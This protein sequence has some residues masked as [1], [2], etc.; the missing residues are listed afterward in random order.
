MPGSSR[1]L[2]RLFWT[3]SVHVETHRVWIVKLKHHC[4]ELHPVKLTAS[5]FL[6]F[7]FLPPSCPHFLQHNVESEN[8][9][10]IAFT[11][12]ATDHLAGQQHLILSCLQPPQPAETTSRPPTHPAGPEPSPAAERCLI[13]H[14]CSFHPSTH[15]PN[16]ALQEFT[17]CPR[18]QEHFSAASADTILIRMQDKRRPRGEIQ[19]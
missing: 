12:P 16:P 18:L 5:L 6:V 7:F 14:M 19:N 11:P 1:K 15:T 9:E 10:P 3:S 13:D 17:L 2:R 8:S 4:L